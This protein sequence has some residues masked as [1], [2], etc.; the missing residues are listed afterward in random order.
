MR[1]FIYA[2]SYNENIGGVI[3]LHK[4]VHIINEYTEHEAFL[5]PNVLE[6]FNF[7]S[8]K[9]I[10]ANFITVVKLIIEKYTYK[11]NPIFNSPLKINVKSND[12][13]DT[14]VVYPEI[15]FGNPLN[16]KNVVRWFLHQPGHLTN[17][18]C[19][20]T[21]E[22]YFKF[23]SAIKNFSLYNSKLSEKELKVIHY[24]METYNQEGLNSERSGTCYLIRKGNHKEKI[25]EENSICID[26]LNHSQ[27]AT[28]FKKSEFF[29]S[30]DDYTAYSI[31][32]ILCGCKSIVV[33]DKDLSINEWYPN[34]SDRF[35]IAYG[36]TEEQNDWA[37]KTKHKVKKLVLDEHKRSIQAV[38][39]FTCEVFD[40]FYKVH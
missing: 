12:L 13:I 15:T 21:G 37:E 22:L 2:P 4:L 35:G 30:Y 11:T 26:G 3:A 8:F 10:L 28:I 29:I 9:N 40:Y 32:A 25:H 6:R 38:Q 27:I 1:F 17:N 24:P 20:S 14:I 19:F 16:A 18:V 31:F 33:P 23:N 34:A 39:D 5:V 36:F 7:R